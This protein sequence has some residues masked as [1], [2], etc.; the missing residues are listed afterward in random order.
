MSSCATAM[1]S[2][3]ITT[4]STG[5]ATKDAIRTAR[6][7]TRTTRMAGTSDAAKAGQVT[8]TT[9]T[10]DPR[11]EG[12]LI[13]GTSRSRPTP[14]A[15]AWRRSRFSRF[16]G[17]GREEHLLDLHDEPRRV[18]LQRFPVGGIVVRRVLLFP[19][20]GAVVTKDPHER[21]RL[22][23]DPRPID[24]EPMLPSYRDHA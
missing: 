9:R 6:I 4:A 3:E 8:T 2:T 14:P 11:T 5:T 24:P 20:T 1:T 19:V 17:D 12:A 22:L 21:V 7:T 10:T 16:Q 18:R 15:P 13:A 23:R